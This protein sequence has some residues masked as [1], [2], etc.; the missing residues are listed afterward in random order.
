[1][2]NSS[3]YMLGLVVSCVVLS[4]LII[5]NTLFAQGGWIEDFSEFDEDLYHIGQNAYCN[6]DEEHFVLTETVAGQMGRIYT[7]DQYPVAIFT[8][9][10]DVFI[11]GGGGSDGMS[12]AIALE[13]D[14]QPTGGGDLNLVGMQGIAL[15]FDTYQNGNH[16]DQNEEHI[17]IV[18]NGPG[19]HLAVWQVNRGDIDCNEWRH[20]RVIN[21]MGDI[22]VFYEDE[23]IIEY[24]YED[25]EPFDA[26]FG[27]TGATGGD[28]NWHRVD[29]VVVTFGGAEIELEEEF[30]EFGPVPTGNAVEHVFQIH[31]VSEEEDEWH[32]LEFSLEDDGEGPDWLTC[33]PAEGIVE[34][35]NSIDITL[36]AD[37]EGLELGEYTR[38]I[39]LTT[40]DFDFQEIILDAHIFVVEGFAQL[41]GTVTNEET[42]DPIGG[43]C[44]EIPAFDMVTE[45]DEE[46]AYIFPEIPSWTYDMLVTMED[47]LPMTAEG[48]EI[49]PGE[50]VVVD[51]GLLHA[52]FIS[53]P[54]Q[55]NEQLAVDE[56]TEV[57]VW[58]NNPG[59]GPLT[60]NVTRV[61]PE[62]ME[63]D[64]WDH[65]A[66]IAVGEIL[67]SNRLGGVE[68]VDDHFYACV[69]VLDGENMIYVLDRDG[70]VVRQFAQLADS[71]YGYRDLTWDGEAFWGVDGN[72]I[73]GFNTA[74]E[75]VGQIEVPVGSARGITWDDENGCFWTCAITSNIFGVDYDGNVVAQIPRP[76]G[77]D[78]RLRT[79][80][81]AHYPDDPDG[82]KIYLFTSDGE[83]NR[84]VWKLDTENREVEFV[85]E[86]D[87]EGT[88]G[89]ATATRRWD[90]FSWIFMA[91]TNSPDRIEIWHLDAP[92]GWV[93]VNPGNGIVPPEERREVTV[94]LDTRDFP[95]DIEFT[96]DL[97]FS[98]DGVGGVNVIPVTL[99]AF[100]EGAMQDRVLDLSRGWSMVSVN[101]DSEEDDIIVLTQELVDND[102]LEIMKNGA[103]QFYSPPFGFNNIPGWAVDQGYLMKVT[104]DCQ[105]T[106]SGLQV[107]ADQPLEL[108]QGWQMIAYFPRVPVDAIIAFSRI[109]EV[110]EMAKDGD[111]QFYSP[112]FR[113][114]NMGNLSEGNGYMV[115]L[116]EAVDLVYT[117]EE[118]IACHQNHRVLQP[119]IL[120]VIT[121]TGYNMS[122]LVLSDDP[123]NYSAEIGVYA[124][125]RLIGSGRIA[126]GVCGIAVW[127]DDLTTEIRDGANPKELLSLKLHRMTGEVEE[128]DYISLA[129]SGH[130]QTNALWAIQLVDGAAPVEFGISA[131][132]PNP[133]NNV[134][135][136]DYSILETNRISIELFNLV[137]QSIGKVFEDVRTAGRH[138]FVWDASDYPSG[139]YMLRLSG[140][141]NTQTQKVLLIR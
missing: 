130:Y 33:D 37:T 126:D 16:G 70:N 38:E 73:Y 24:V 75:Q 135:N 46:G 15:E 28:H 137:G 69:G 72:L 89:A 43:A 9:E 128:L 27:F 120:P 127:G 52:D 21:V 102:L 98:H 116:T 31:N 48:V 140:G 49:N 14:Y 93:D 134:T 32:C 84:Q 138:R 82:Y 141:S 45:S 78:G 2:L 68:F 107:P 35:G 90:P 17:A 59:N 125:G 108:S 12:F 26:H 74:G 139:V 22:Q 13:P 85:T 64:P 131:I 7:L 61:F 77:P 34:A 47:F 103:G 60:W 10:F 40:N 100:G 94:T 92:T 133:F 20:V 95:L 50:E 96:V 54:D 41:S 56:N 97:V 112:A 6:E 23:L 83:V 18:L 36:T 113:F 1:M 101:V 5:P 109:V 3:K 62:G 8:A 66:G 114:S 123:V 19:N 30:F 63:A 57:P 42:G 110:L 67:E 104:E 117:V 99:T 80:G 88:A 121:P 79:Y 129:G 44:V 106:I 76:E 29:N 25:F 53:N 119:E 122:L 86:P 51:F 132:W 115:K 136:I 91:L 71:R 124:S 11:G 4:L 111:G 58:I 87:V 55:I 105:L 39:L 65:R 81:M 118:E